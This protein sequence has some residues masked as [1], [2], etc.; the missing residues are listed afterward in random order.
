[1]PV[2]P[3]ITDVLRVTLNWNPAHGI[4]PRNVWHF[5]APGKTDAQLVTALNAAWSANL[6]DW[7]MQDWAFTTIDILHLDGT[8][9]TNTYAVTAQGSAVSGDWLPGVS[10]VLSYRTS[11]RGSRGRGRSFF[12]PMPE[13]KVTNGLV[14]NAVTVLA[15]HNA[16]HGAL[17]S[18]G[19]FFGVASYKHADFNQVTTTR[20]DTITGSS[21]RRNDQQR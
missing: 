21:R 11:Q 8:S 2:L 12:G 17:A 14:N 4:T 5:Y 18:S 19:F 15:A 7:V 1:M 16:F 9:A 6:W 3:T 10:G 20:A 13:S